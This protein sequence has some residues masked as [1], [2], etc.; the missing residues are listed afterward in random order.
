MSPRST[1]APPGGRSRWLAC[2]A[3][4]LATASLGATGAPRAVM[5]DE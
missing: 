5:L 3:A 1:S 4:L 2:L